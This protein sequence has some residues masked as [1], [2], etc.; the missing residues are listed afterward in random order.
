MRTTIEEL[1][2]QAKEWGVRIGHTPHLPD[3]LM[4]G[5]YDGKNKVIWLKRGMSPRQ[6]IC[7]LAHELSHAK[8]DDAGCLSDM[9]VER[10]A[11]VEAARMLLST[12]EYEEAEKRCYS[13]E[14][15]AIAVELDVMVWVVKAFRIW[16]HDI[17]RVCR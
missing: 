13:S 4:M 17:G 6:E 16:L 9:S 12:E 1:E 14:D 15:G 5:A 2:A 8:H 10:R 3:A 11:D 7:T